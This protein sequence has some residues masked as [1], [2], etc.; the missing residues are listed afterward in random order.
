MKSSLARRLAR[1]LVG[2]ALAAATLLTA[3]GARAYG[4]PN[5]DWWTVETPHFRVHYDRPLEPIANRVATLAETIHGRV[6]KALGYVPTEV[7]QIVLT[8]DTDDANGSATALP[9]NTI[10]L[11]VTAPDD[12]SPIGD[13]DDWYTELVTHEYT[14]IAHTDNMSG[15]ARVA[16]AVIGKQVA[17]NQTQPH[18]ILEGLAVVSES[19]HSSAGRIRSSL[20]DMFLRADVLDGRIAP[21]DQV[22]NSAYRWP[23]GNLWYLYG[24]RF[25]RWIIDLYGPNTM[26]A[27]SADYG[28]NIIPW[29]INRSIRRATGRTYV[30]LYEGFKDH[31]KLLYAEQTREVERR[32]LRE[33][34]RITAHGRTVS[35][36]RFLPRVARSG[37]AEELVYFRDDGDA[38]P[39]LYRLPLAAPKKG[40][41]PE[42]LVVRTSGTSSPT[43]TP[44][45]DLV[46]NSVAPWQN[47]YPRNDLFFLAKGETAKG[48]D[49]SVRKKLTTGLRAN[50]ADVSPDGRRLVF[51]VNGK[52][53][54]Y[55]EIG[56]LT[57]EGEIKNRRD[58]VRSAQFEQAYTPRFSPDGRTVAYSVWTAGGYRDVRLVDVATGIF[59]EVT[60][61]RAMDMNPI[62]SPDGKTLFFSSDR[63]GI[64]NVY[65]YDV[66][67]GTLLQVTNVKVGA[68]QPAISTDGKTLVYVGYTTYGFDL[69]SMPLEPARFLAAL[70][71]PTD[72]PD[73]P[74][75]PEPTE[76]ARHPYSAW[77]TVGPRGY[78]LNITPGYYGSN[79][80]I[81]QANGSDVV[82]L[83]NVA[84]SIQIDPSAPEP[85][86]TFDYAYNRLPFDFNVHFFHQVV[87]RSG[88]IY[89]GQNLTYDEYTNGLTTG[90]SY[91]AQEEFS[92]HTIGASFSVA[93][94]KGNIPVAGGVDPYAPAQA[95]P[96]S[97][98]I[99]VLHVGYSYSNVEGSIETAGALRGVSLGFGVDY[100]SSF[101]GSSW[102]VRAFGGSIAG[103]VP[104]PWPGHHTLALRSSGAFAGGT[105]PRAGLYYVG[106]YDFSNS[107]PS[108]ILSGVFNGAFVL[109]GYPARVYAGNEYLLENVEYRAPL[110]ITDR[111]LSTLPLFLRRLDAALFWDFGGAF[112]SLDLHAIHLFHGGSIIDSPQLHTSIGAELW[113]SLTLGYQLNAQ[114]RIGYAKGFS[115]EAIPH[116]QPYFV[117][118]S[119][120]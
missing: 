74:T 40:E 52:G 15:L 94:F 76:L 109:R 5:L 88:Y 23:G 80:L 73:P 79:T 97:G 20:F 83:H 19:E 117:A 54:T 119:A 110:W 115:P 91:T 50:Y 44:T 98:N 16:N 106:G 17:P 116:G 39:G 13:Y 35:Y 118:S 38:R 31:I 62:W 32:G 7:T 82:G 102:D 111:G 59:R 56:D 37:D 48:G 81:V 45:G 100:G 96:P 93:S 36:P 24:S 72:R 28:S 11:Y 55:L 58:L 49:D 67:K 77:P 57:A 71:A 95:D 114:L 108:T 107:L 2:S 60:H 9:Y 42:E 41:R 34:T 47:Y 51:T 65:A 84:A 86:F 26:R 30:E 22:S 53:T 46:F 27:V 112:N 3:A 101:L 1:G 87:P 10:R 14:H 4:D 120:F 75:E 85:N 104:M 8:D 68:V 103:Y 113:V 78:L 21:L 18:W 64:F 69:F 92:S 63:T 105:Y 99:N 61:D 43:F 66:A 12:L 6:A 25:L 70:P 29:G 89:Q 90:V 33:G